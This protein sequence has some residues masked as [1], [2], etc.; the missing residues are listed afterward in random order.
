MNVSTYIADNGE[1]ADSGEN[2]KPNP[3]KTECR[4]SGSPLPLASDDNL[5]AQGDALQACYWGRVAGAPG[6]GLSEKVH[7]LPCLETRGTTRGG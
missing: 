4:A 5:A 1:L 3:C 2:V 6:V 7:V